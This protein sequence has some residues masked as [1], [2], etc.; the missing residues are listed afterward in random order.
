MKIYIVYDN[1]DEDARVVAI[2][3]DDNSACEYIKK[4]N[5]NLELLDRYYDLSPYVRALDL[6]VETANL[7][8]EI[9]RLS[10]GV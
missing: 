9:A 8:A 1:R 4:Y 7:E 10:K 3:S 6:D 2:F 5:A